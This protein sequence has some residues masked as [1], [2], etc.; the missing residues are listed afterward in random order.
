MSEEN[1]VDKKET[2]SENLESA[3]NIITN[4]PKNWW[5]SKTI[6]VNLGAIV[7]MVAAKYGFNVALSEEMLTSIPLILGIVNIFL[8]SITHKPIGK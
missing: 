6:W 4:D 7:T 1:N 2:I 5:K 3:S 8:R